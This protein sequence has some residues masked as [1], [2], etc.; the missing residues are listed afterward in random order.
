MTEKKAWSK[1]YATVLILNIAYILI[2]YIIMN[3]YS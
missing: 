2:F 1:N 3:T